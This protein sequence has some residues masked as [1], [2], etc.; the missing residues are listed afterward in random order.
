MADA[1]RLKAYLHYASG[2]PVLSMARRD[3][4]SMT[5]ASPG[6]TLVDIT[7]TPLAAVASDASVVA[8]YAHRYGPARAQVGVIRL[9]PK[10]APN[11][12]NTDKYEVW[13]NLPSHPHFATMLSAAS[14]ENNQNLRDYLAATVF[15]TKVPPDVGHQSP[16]LPATVQILLQKPS[17]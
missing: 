7:K 2:H 5:S 11:I 15:L 14:T 10:D 9:D 12:Y 17:Q 8:S 13:E 4:A 6:T 16:E 1:P 3:W